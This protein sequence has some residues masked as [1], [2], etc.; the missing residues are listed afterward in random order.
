MYNAAR[1]NLDHQ[2][3]LSPPTYISPSSAVLVFVAI[4][5]L[6]ASTKKQGGE[7]LLSL[8]YKSKLAH[9]PG[10][11]SVSILDTRLHENNQLFQN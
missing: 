8:A 9:F 7:L 5:I 4:F 2:L 3:S 1:R 6:G 11:Q 10:I